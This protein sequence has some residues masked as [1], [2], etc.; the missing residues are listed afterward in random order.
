MSVSSNDP[1]KDYWSSDMPCEPIVAATF[2]KELLKKQGE[3]FGEDGLWSRNVIQWAPGMN[4]HRSPFNSRNH[5]YYSEDPMLTGLCGMNFV[6][7][8][9]SKGMLLSAKHF[10]FN[11]QESFREGLCQFMEEQS[12]REIELRGFE[13]LTNAEYENAAGNKISALGLMSSFSRVGVTCINAHTGVIKNILRGEWGFKGFVSTD[14]VV[15]GNYFKPQD[16]VYNNVTFMATSNADNLLSSYWPEYN[17]KSKVKGD[18]KLM[19][20]LYD[21]MHYYMYAL[22]NSSALNGVSPDTVIGSSVS[23][24]QTALVVLASLFGVLTVG[25]AVC[26]AIPKLSPSVKEEETDVKD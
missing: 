25:T 12:A 13:Q 22:A 8:G 24:W 21:N 23:W 19:T 15:G 11:M 5:E 20:A 4:I 7:G 6:E 9:L 10:A 14:M 18:P 26:I 2:D 3:I 17:D 1:N 16:C